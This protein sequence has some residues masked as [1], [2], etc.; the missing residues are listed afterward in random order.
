MY[1]VCCL[2]TAVTA[3]THQHATS[4]TVAAVS[5]RPSP[6][7]DVVQA[8]TTSPHCW[9]VVRPVTGKVRLMEEKIDILIN[10]YM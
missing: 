6:T 7:Q 1:A 3:W 5:V 8:S 9:P 2:A 10:V 4:T